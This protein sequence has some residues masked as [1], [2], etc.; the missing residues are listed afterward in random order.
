MT[1]VAADGDGQIC[2][3]V[4][5]ATVTAGDGL[6][7]VTGPAGR[8]VIGVDG[9]IRVAMMRNKCQAG[10]AAACRAKGGAVRQKRVSLP[11]RRTW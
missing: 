8:T 9:E 6:I 7:T 3:T 2:T 10:S 5:G 11:R 1:I 4:T